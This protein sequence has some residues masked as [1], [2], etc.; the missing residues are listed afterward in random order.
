MATELDLEESPRD[1]YRRMSRVKRLGMLMVVLGPETAAVLLK[2]FDT[3]QAQ[4]ICK[5]IS[6]SSIIDTEM[7]EMVLEE[8]SEIIEESVNSQLGGMDF[9]QK[10]LTLAHGDY[11]ANSMMNKIAPVR[12]DLDL[13]DEID[14]MEPGQ[15]YNVLRMEQMQTVAFVLSNVDSEKGGD[16]LKM[17]PSQMQEQ[18]IERVGAM[19]TTQS[20]QASLVAD[21]LTGRMA[22]KEKPTLIKMGG[23]KTAA[24]ML[25]WIDKEE[26]K[27]LIKNLEKRNPKLGSSIR[28]RM[29]RFEDLVRLSP[30]DVA[31]ITKEVDQDDFILALK[32]ASHELK[33]VIFATMSRRA[34]E[35][36]EEQLEFLGPKRM[37][38]IEA[39]QDRVIQI[40]RELEDDE[41]IVLDTGGGD[42]VVQ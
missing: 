42:V 5:E 18:I 22:K 15:I 31:K 13:M 24:D 30:T 21:T 38:E 2:R 12:D 7:Q 17:F 32:N 14:D 39:A 4:A 28:K 11:R 26:G 19:E 10:A 20:D 37:S 9:T 40:V 16:V 6:E 33:K 34:V 23:V 1:I 8:F 3:K 29:F 25:N 36:W 27:E 41:E 35:N